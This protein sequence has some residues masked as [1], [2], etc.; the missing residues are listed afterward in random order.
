M[1]PD[2][3][4]AKTSSGEGGPSEDCFWGLEGPFGISSQCLPGR[5]LSCARSWARPLPGTLPPFSLGWSWNCSQTWSQLSDRWP[6]NPYSWSLSGTN[7][8]DSHSPLFGRWGNEGRR[9]R[10]EEDLDTLEHR[11]CLTPTSRTRSH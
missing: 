7:V 4:I 9:S 1:G 5:H 6:R 3:R 2:Q 11:R 10:A 8:L